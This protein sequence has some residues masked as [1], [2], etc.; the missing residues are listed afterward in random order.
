MTCLTVY[1]MHYYNFFSKGVF[2][3]IFIFS[4]IGG[5]AITSK[6]GLQDPGDQGHA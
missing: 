3:F 6:G 1:V 2:T 4:A 5:A